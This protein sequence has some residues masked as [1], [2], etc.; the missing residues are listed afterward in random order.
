MRDA[1][2]LYPGDILFLEN[3]ESVG[4]ASG[5]Y[6]VSEVDIQL[7]PAPIAKI[8][9]GEAQKLLTDYL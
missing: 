7:S 9:V 5:G 2:L 8:V 6:R 4:V 1:F 3:G